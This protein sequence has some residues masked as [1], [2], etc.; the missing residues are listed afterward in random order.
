MMPDFFANFT[1]ILIVF[2]GIFCLMGIAM[3]GAVL[4]W[5]LE[6]LR[7]RDMTIIILLGMSLSAF[8]VIF[9]VAML[10]LRPAIT[11]AVNPAAI[12]TIQATAEPLPTATPTPAPTRRVRGG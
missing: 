4:G 3:F 5:G 9:L 10:L 2:F 12:P 7:R 8:L 1:S 6:I 11:N